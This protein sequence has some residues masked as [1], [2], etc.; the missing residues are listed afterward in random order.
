MIPR[1]NWVVFLILLMGSILCRSGYAAESGAKVF[2]SGSQQVALLELFTSEGCSSC[3]PADAWMNGLTHSTGL[4]KTFVPVAFHVDYWNYL[5]WKDGLSSPKYSNRQR[6]YA[7]SWNSANI[8]TPMVVCNGKESRE[9][10]QD[11][12][13]RTQNKNEVGILEIHQKEKA[14]F[15]ITFS[16]SGRNFSKEI[17]ASV[18]YLGC[19]IVTHVTSGEN[20]GEDLPHDFAVLSF[21]QKKLD[22][23]EGVLQATIRLDS[24]D[25]V[26][27]PRH[28]VAV[29]VSEVGSEQPLQATGGFL[30]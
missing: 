25:P 9:W 5:G 11:S 13:L 17:E 6:D 16:P 15:Q 3:P 21:V 23:R 30:D 7:A 12:A 27:A 14:E 22:R 29:W 1:S 18:A 28:A 2:Q 24:T 4:W 20:R 19:G 26:K 8:Y 10:F